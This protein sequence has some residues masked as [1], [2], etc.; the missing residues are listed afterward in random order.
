MLA[1]GFAVSLFAAMLA[2]T[3]WPLVHDAALMDYIAFLIR[4]GFAPY[5]DIIDM[6]MPGAYMLRL[7]LTGLFGGTA[8]G[9]LAWQII[10][11]LIVIASCIYIVG[12][13]RRWVGLLAGCM[14][15]LIHISLGSRDFGQRDWNVAVLLV[16]CCAFLIGYLRTRR[17]LLIFAGVAL[18]AFAASIKPPAILFPA[19]AVAYICSR[20]GCSQPAKRAPLLAWAAA[21]LLPAACASVLFLARYHAFT[22]FFSTTRSLDLYYGSLAHPGFGKLALL[23]LA[24]PERLLLL[25]VAACVPLYF[26]DRLWQSHELNIIGLGALCG[27]LSYLVQDK[28]FGYQRLPAWVFLCLWIAFVIDAGIR[29]RRTWAHVTTDAMCVLVALVAPLLLV[30]SSM[31][32]YPLTTIEHLQSDLNGMGGQHLSGRVQCLDITLGGCVNVLYRMRLMQSTGNV[33]DFYLF[34]NRPAAI[35]TELQRRFLDQVTDHPPEVIVLSSHIWPG[36]RFGYDEVARWPEFQIFLSSRY[37]LDR[38]YDPPSTR[39]AGYRIYS[40]K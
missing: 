31:N 19:L 23:S 39:T 38:Q 5:R 27:I 1:G 29:Q 37:R 25:V 26:K 11:T 21:G 35:T 13:E 3:R 18:A 36:E 22:A 10:E 8:A 17:V 12:P 40:L 9:L 32:P 16:V 20:P 2:A 33:S 6:N 15:P 7:A 14:S 24:T 30:M 34:P 4:G 28:G